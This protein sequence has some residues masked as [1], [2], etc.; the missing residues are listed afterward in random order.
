MSLTPEEIKDLPESVRKLIVSYKI[1]ETTFSSDKGS[2]GEKKSIELKFVSK[3]K[4]AEMLA[5]HIGFYEE[6]NNQK[7]DKVIVVG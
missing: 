3:E 2:E 1:N 6:H 7:G 5:K 4:A